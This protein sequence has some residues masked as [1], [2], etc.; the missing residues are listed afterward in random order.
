MEGWIKLYRKLQESWIWKEK[1]KFS[2]FEAWL[3]ILLKANHKDT[4]AMINGKVIIVKS[5]SFITSEVKLAEDWKWDRKT[6]R[7]FLSILQN[8]KMIQK[9]A[10]TEYTRISIENWNLYQNEGQQKGQRN[11]QR[12]GHK[13][14]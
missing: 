3:D 13:Q 6:V 5:G 7:K 10:T 11:G 8:E 14:E 2:K 9:N 4:K 1:R 12:N